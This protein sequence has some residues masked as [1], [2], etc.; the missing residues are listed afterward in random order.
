[1]PLIIPMH[2][3]FSLRGKEGV[4]HKSKILYGYLSFSRYLPP[5]FAEMIFSRNFTILFPPFSYGGIGFTWFLFRIGKGLHHTLS[6]TSRFFPEASKFLQCLWDSLRVLERF[7]S[8]PACSSIPWP[9]A[10]RLFYKSPTSSRLPRGF[11]L[12]SSSFVYNGIL[13][14]F[15]VSVTQGKA[16]TQKMKTQ[17]TNGK[18]ASYVE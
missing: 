5:D 9:F 16:E 17:R 10:T 13:P 4:V 1:M 6:R 3:N 12:H 18:M 15:S 14:W 7:S 11:F 2:G 8:T